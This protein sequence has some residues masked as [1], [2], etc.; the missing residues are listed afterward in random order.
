MN[1]LWF[2]CLAFVAFVAC[3][4]DPTAENNNDADSPT[5]GDADSDTDSESDADTDAGYDADEND[6]ADEINDADE[7]DADSPPDAEI[8]SGPLPYQVPTIPSIDE[9]THRV[10]FDPDWTGAESGT[11][12]EPYNSFSDIDYTFESDTA[13]LIR[14]GTTIDWNRHT[15]VAFNDVYLGKYGEGDFASIDLLH[16]FHP[17]TGVENL[18]VERIHFKQNGSSGW[19]KLVQF[20]DNCS[21]VTFANCKF[22]GIDVGQGFPHYGIRGSCDNFILYHS[23][24]FH[25]RDDGIYGSHFPDSF[26]V[27][28]Y[29]HHVNFESGAGDGIQFEGCVSPRAYLA[30][31]VIDRSNS[32]QKFALIINNPLGNPTP[33]P[34]MIVEWNTF[35]SPQTGQGGAAVR[36]YAGLETMFRYNLINTETGLSGMDGW[37]DFLNQD[38][39]YGVY[40]NHEY[41]SAVI[42]N[43]SLDDPTNLDFD[44]FESFQAYLFEHDLDPYGSD[45]DTENFWT[46]GSLLS[47]HDGVQNGDE[48]GIDCGRSCG[49]C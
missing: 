31:N 42:C 38:E 1:R 23:E 5:D 49:P 2:V 45:L 43:Q 30:N 34:G 46:E 39:P 20:P 21:H 18:I 41:G 35:V 17:T 3:S 4:K 11:I 36:W 27:S 6:D 25:L 40:E 22:E 24:I 47:C 8:P 32:E 48:L 16:T 19:R 15:T 44:D 33:S 10:Y 14:A 29:I 9:F 7:N 12:D 26:F 28:N 13:Y 37:S